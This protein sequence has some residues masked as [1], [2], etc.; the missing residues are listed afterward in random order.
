VY[1][2]WG[3]KVFETTE[4]DQQCWD[5]TFRGKELNSGIYAYKIRVTLTDGTYVEESG[6]LTLLR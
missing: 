5:G 1:D 3:E 6:N 4:V 2:R